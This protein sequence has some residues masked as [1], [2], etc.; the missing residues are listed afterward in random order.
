MGLEDLKRWLREANLK[1]DPERI[2][3]ELVVRLVQVTF[4]DE[5]VLEEVAWATMFLITKVKGEYWVIGMLEVL[6]R[7]P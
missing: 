3:W 5:N 1:K 6:W 7:P 2:K 4:E